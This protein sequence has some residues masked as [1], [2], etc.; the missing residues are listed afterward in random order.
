[1]RAIFF[2]AISNEILL[3]IPSRGG[4]VFREGETVWVAREMQA[5]GNFYFNVNM[6]NEQTREDF[7]AL[8]SR[9]EGDT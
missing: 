6:E 8:R 4:N 2:N 9:H 5:D 7:N 3:D 1:M